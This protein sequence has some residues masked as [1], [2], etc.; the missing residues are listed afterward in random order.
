MEDI[1]KIRTLL[2][3]S[4]F[5]ISG[6]RIISDS[7][8]EIPKNTKVRKCKKCRA[9]LSMYNQNDICWPCEERMPSAA[10]RPTVQPRRKITKIQLESELSSLIT[11]QAKKNGLVLE[12]IYLLSEQYEQFTKLIVKVEDMEPFAVCSFKN[13]ELK[14]ELKILVSDKEALDLLMEIIIWHADQKM[15]IAYFRPGD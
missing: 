14:R 11:N 7:G 3:K 12:D 1:E 10:L 13:A 5:H 8:R 6:E 2:E 4:G 15:E 9:K